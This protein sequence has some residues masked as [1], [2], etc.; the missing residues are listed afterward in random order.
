MDSA[1]DLYIDDEGNGVIRRVDHLTHV[2]T[3]YAGGGPSGY[4]GDGGP[5]TGANLNAPCTIALDASGNL[6]I[7]DSG[8]HRIREVS[9]S[10]GIITTVAGDGAAGYTGD[11]GPATSTS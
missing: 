11:N 10:A 9:V 7:A 2:I 3:T 5:A 8:N 6:F 4:L 1:G